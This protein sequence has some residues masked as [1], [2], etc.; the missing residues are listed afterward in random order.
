MRGLTQHADRR[1][2]QRGIPPLIIQWLLLYG[3][4]CRDQHGCL[5]R[6]FSHRSVRRLRRDVGSQPIRELRKYLNAYAVEG[7]DTGAIVTVGWRYR[8]VKS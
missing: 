6:F 7:G 2:S 1:S 3:E 5:I 8:R 4:E